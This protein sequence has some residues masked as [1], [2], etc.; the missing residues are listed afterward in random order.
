MALDGHEE[1]PLNSTTASGNF[2]PTNWSA[3]GQWLLGPCRRSAQGRFETCLAP[4]SAA[5][6]VESAIRVVAT[7]PDLNLF[8]ARFSPDQRW[9]AI[10]GVEYGGVSTIYAMRA[11]GGAIAPITEGIH[12][13]D[14]PCWGRTAAR[15][16]SFPIGVDS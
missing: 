13:D 8:I 11:S 14:K 10:Q 4:L 1:T 9:I 6:H 15:S 7:H 12:W 2:E 16:T 5:P 3:D